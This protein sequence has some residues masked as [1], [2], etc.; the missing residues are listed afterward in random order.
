VA[1]HPNRKVILIT[2]AYVYHD[3][4]RYDWK[5]KGK[6]QLWNPYAYGTAEDP[7]RTSDGEDLWQKL[8]RKHSGFA[9][10]LSGHV[11]RDGLGRLSSRGDHKNLVHQMLVNYQMRVLGGEGYL[12]LLEFFPD[13]KTVQVKAYSPYLD[14]YLTDGQNQFV[15]DLDPGLAA[16]QEPAPAPADGKKP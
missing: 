8:V 6:A 7:E 13:G 15:F 1:E 11:L 5:A 16:P 3:N 10:V 9:M 4:S 2:H 12:R 14:L